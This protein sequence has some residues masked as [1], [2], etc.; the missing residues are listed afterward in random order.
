MT[1]T[2]REIMTPNPITVAIEATAIEA[3]QAMRDHD[4]GNVVVTEG[5]SVCGIL[6]DRDIAIAVSPAATTPRSRLRRD[7]QPRAHHGQRRCRRRGSRAD[8]A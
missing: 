3:A 4:V 1:Q 5:G 7:L 2:L 8:H 6:T